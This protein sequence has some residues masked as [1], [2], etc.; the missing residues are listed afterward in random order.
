MDVNRLIDDLGYARSP[1]FLRP[2]GKNSLDDA[3]DFGHIFR[4]AQGHCKLRGVYTLRHP[5]EK[6]RDTVVPVVYVC[7]AEDEC[8]AER[9]HK[10]VWNQNVVPFLILAAPKTVRLYSGFRYERQQPDAAP[11]TTGLLRAASDMKS[12]LKFL[13]AFRADHIDDGSVWEDWGRE[14]T[15][16]TKVDWRLL[17]S[18]NDLDGWLQANGITDP[19]VSHALIGKYVYLNYLRKREILSDLWLEEWGLEERHLFGRQAKASSFWQLVR[20]LD[21]RLNGSVFPLPKSG[22]RMPKPEHI[23]KVAATFAGDDPSSGQLALDF[24]LYDFSF[25]PIETLSVIYEQFLHSPRSDGG[26]SPGKEKG[27]YY[28]PLPLVNFMLEELDSFRPF[29]EK[30]RVLDPAC[31]SGAF[32]VQCFRRIIEQDSEFKPGAPMRPARLGEL[33][34]QHIFGIDRDE[35]ACRVAELSLTLTLLDYVDPPD[36]HHTPQFRL[37][38]LHGTNIHQGD[39]F[40][41]E[42]AWR[43]KLAGVEFDWIV[44]NPPWIE[45]KRAG[46]SEEDHCV[47]DWMQDRENRT[48]FP[49]GGNQVAEAFAWK[50]MEHL[51]EQGQ[52]ALLLPAMTLFKIES[53]SFRK[54]FFASAQVHSVA[55]F[56]NLAEVL[57]PGHPYRRGKRIDRTRP[58]RPAAALFYSKGSPEQD[59]IRVFSPLV[60]EQPANRPSEPGERKDAWNIVIHSNQI[61]TLSNQIRTL[62]CY[63]VAGGSAL[64]WKA[65]MWGSSHDIRLLESVSKRHES[66]ETFCT[67]NELRHAEGFQLR[68]AG[69]KEPTDPMPELAGKPLLDVTRLRECGLIFEFPP[70]A[71][72]TIPKEQSFVR[73]GRGRLPLLVSQPPHIVVD[74]ARRF[75]VYSDEFIAVPPRQIGIRGSRKQSSLLKALSLY[76]VS[77]FANYHQFL[78]TPQWGISTSISTLGALR[79]L[80]VPL[81]Q[82]SESEVAEW[83]E[84]HSRVVQAARHQGNAGS[85]FDKRLLGAESLVSLLDEINERVFRA[86]DVSDFERALVRDLVHVRMSLIQG[87]VDPIATRAPAESEMRKYGL[88]LTDELDAF[89]DDQPSLKHSTMIAY[90]ERAAIVRVRLHKSPFSGERIRIHKSEATAAH[91]LGSIRDRVRKKHSQWVYFERELRLYEGRDTYVLKPMERLH[92]TESQATLDAGTIIAETLS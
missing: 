7:E 2:G 74:E 44:G 23:R 4:R 71:L 5:E 57:F 32:L 88:V 25:I 76:L 18:L 10:S 81:S 48:R 65:A 16:S 78:A 53:T 8:E 34:E 24:G 28:T 90:D 61:R 13:E 86:L 55:N 46:V 58:R 63:E 15:P 12:A 26:E 68:S 11:E 6:G 17:S 89:V 60:V 92:W 47:W 75:A 79:E 83:A 40:D 14:V 38:N 73:R 87:K 21:D 54:M 31:G 3:A 70:S 67:R 59:G 20:Q 84:L 69:G 22:A 85:L 30:M 1:N 27:A 50:V 51:S 37:P 9:I 45:L 43:G 80:P 64:P 91:D 35:D 39:F 72:K 42:A 49:V 36:L 41:P 29:R 52:V 82:L 33:L 62:D 56:A 66:F 77:D 19:E